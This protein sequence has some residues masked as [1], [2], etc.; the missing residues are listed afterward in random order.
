MSDLTVRIRLSTPTARAMVEILNAYVEMC[1]GPNPD[2]DLVTLADELADMLA[3][4][5][6]QQEI[7]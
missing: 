7:S 1:G 2:L 6:V 3:D 4:G 5:I